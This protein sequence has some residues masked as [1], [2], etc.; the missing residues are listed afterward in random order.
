M[1]DTK[2]IAVRLPLADI[3]KLDAIAARTCR[4][5]ADLLRLLV[6]MAESSGVPDVRFVGIPAAVVGDDHAA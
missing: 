5:R 3:T 1:I 6:A 2:P 4:T